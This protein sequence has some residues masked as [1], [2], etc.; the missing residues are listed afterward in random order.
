VTLSLSRR[1]LLHGVNSCYYC[2]YK[3]VAGI[4]CVSRSVGACNIA[5]VYVRSVHADA[6]CQFFK[7]FMCHLFSFHVCMYVRTLHSFAATN[8]QF[9]FAEM[10]LQYGHSQLE[11]RYFTNGF[12]SVSSARDILTFD[13]IYM[14]DRTKVFILQEQCLSMCIYVTET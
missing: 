7:R 8:W 10:T 6:P 12:T 14:M 3:T 4:I 9:I 11:N 5:D 1:T 2:E 13:A